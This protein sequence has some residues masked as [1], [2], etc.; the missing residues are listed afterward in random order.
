MRAV[1]QKV[2]EADV[3][4]VHNTDLMHISHIDRGLLVLLGIGRDD[5]NADI[6]YIA[7]KLAHMRIFSDADGKMNLSIQDIGGEILLISQFT[8]FGD[9]RNGRRPS[10]ASAATPQQA[11]MLYHDLTDRLMDMG[12][13]VKTGHFQTHMQVSL[14]NNGPVTI[15]LDSKKQF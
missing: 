7:D 1:V 5:T 2:L 12:L 11:L 4:V 14:N 3:E 6:A 15:L 8:L 9:L 10:F 13:V